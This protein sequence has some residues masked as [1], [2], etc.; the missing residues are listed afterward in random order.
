M[1][2]HAA[3]MLAFTALMAWLPLLSSPA[4]A[5]GPSAG[6]IAGANYKELEP[7]QPVE[8]A[9][10]TVEVIEFLWYD[11]ETCFVVE[12]ALQRWLKERA[13][14][15]TFRRVPAVVGGHMLYYARVFY[16]AEELGVLD[17]VHMPL[18]T[19]IHRYSRPLST[20]EQMAGFFAEHGVERGRFLSTFRN[21]VTASKV[22]NAQVMSRNYDVAGAPTF[23]VGG[24]YRV[25][26][27][28]VPNVET[29]LQVVGFLVDRERGAKK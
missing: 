28:M 23:V 29:M 10:G 12:S 22:R 17:D 6:I 16:T 4:R 7:A 20:E 26:P 5:A 3:M 13:G 27:T 1:S 24:K 14:T 15:V 18:Y 9:P 11:C 2:R 8:A 21:S 19:A 25:D